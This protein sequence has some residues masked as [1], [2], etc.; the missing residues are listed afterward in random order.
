MGFVS[1]PVRKQSRV[2]ASIICTD[3]LSCEEIVYQMDI[4]IL[5]LNLVKILKACILIHY[6]CIYL[7]ITKKLYKMDKKNAS[8]L[9]RIA[10]CRMVITQSRDLC[11]KL[12]KSLKG[13]EAESLSVLDKKITEIRQKLNDVLK[14]LPKPKLFITDYRKFANMINRLRADKVLM[15]SVSLIVNCCLFVFVFTE[16]DFTKR[17]FKRIIDDFDPEKD[18]LIFNKD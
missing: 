3:L 16:D 15:G 2:Y 13:C 7:L 8:R 11:T 18:G 10:E 6:C 12:L 1:W 5:S 9:G 17:K 14:L 4:N